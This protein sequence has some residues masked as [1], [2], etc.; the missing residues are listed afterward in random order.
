MRKVAVEGGMPWE[1]RGWMQ[2]IRSDKLNISTGETELEVVQTNGIRQRSPDSPVLFAGLVADRL[3]GILRTLENCQQPLPTSG[4]VTWTPTS[5][6]FR[7]STYK[8]VGAVE[9]V[10][11]VDGLKINGDKTQGTCSAA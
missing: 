11:A 7:P 2:L 9:T 1:A 5:G 8:I 4:G 3:G 10:L 6:L